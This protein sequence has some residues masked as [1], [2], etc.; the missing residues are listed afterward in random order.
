MQNNGTYPDTDPHPFL[1]QQ[2]AHPRLPAIHPWYKL[3]DQILSGLSFSIQYRSA[4]YSLSPEARALSAVWL[5]SASCLPENSAHWSDY[6]YIHLSV[7]H[8]LRNPIHLKC[9]TDHFFWHAA[10]RLSP[11]HPVLLWSHGHKSHW[12][13]SLHPHRQCHP[14]NNWP[15]RKIPVCPPWKSVPADLW[16]P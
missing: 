12:Q 9:H 2:A 3:P 10:V 15:P 14:L 5:Y 4:W 7:D 13:S 16:Y 11:L 8:I 1:T 6:K